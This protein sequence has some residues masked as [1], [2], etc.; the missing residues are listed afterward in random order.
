MSEKWRAEPRSE[1]DLG[2]PTVRDRR[3]AF[4][5][6]DMVKLGT[7]VTDRKGKVGTLHLS[8][9]ALHFYPDI[10]ML[11][12]VGVGAPIGCPFY[13][14]VGVRFPRATRLVNPPHRFILENP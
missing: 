5:N 11:R 12:S 8:V 1:L 6:V 10:C 9:C 14:A 3:G 7:R 13:P 4:R 2:N